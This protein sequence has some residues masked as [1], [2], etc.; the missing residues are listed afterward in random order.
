MEPF[1]RARQDSQKEQRRAAI[2]D[3]ASALFDAQP[4]GA[5]SIDAIARACGVAKGSIYSYFT[6]K[7][8]IFLGVLMRE[9]DQWCDALVSHLV[10]LPPPV[11]HEAL[12]D[13][14]LTTLL[15]RERLLRL[16]SRLAADL[17]PHI[18][19][20][21]ALAFKRWLLSRSAVVG[22]RMELAAPWIAPGQGGRVLLRLN[23]LIAGLWPMA[24]SSGPMAV[25]L[26]RPEMAALCVDFPKELR[27]MLLATLKHP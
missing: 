10:T 20:D 12:C 9:V 24:N 1:I 15:P 14:I 11:S 18:S 3:A 6:T 19:A 16:L 25:V 26:D 8:E 21:A 7:E 27:A 23:A 13:A 2:L 22:V 4:V 17:E 5:I